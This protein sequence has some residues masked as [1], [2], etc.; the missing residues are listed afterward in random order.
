MPEF[1]KVARMPEAAPRSAG[2]TLLMIAEVF[3]AENMPRADAVE[4]DQQRERPV[5]EVDREQQQADE[6]G[7][8]DQQAAG[9]EASATPNR[10]ER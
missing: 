7:R 1:W 5:G 3:G 6:A 10:S 2:G 4:H 9:G 8:E